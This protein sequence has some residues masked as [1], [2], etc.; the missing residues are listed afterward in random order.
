MGNISNNIPII[1]TRQRSAD[2]TSMDSIGA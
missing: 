2:Y 1:I